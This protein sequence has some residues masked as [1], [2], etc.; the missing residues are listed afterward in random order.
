MMSFTEYPSLAKETIVSE[1]CL[2]IAT[3]VIRSLF[4][5]SS[6]NCLKGTSSRTLRAWSL[7]IK[8]ES[9]ISRR[10]ISHHQ[11]ISQNNLVLP[12]RHPFW[13]FWI[14]LSL[15]CFRKQHEQRPKF[16]TLSALSGTDLQRNFLHRK[17]CYFPKHTMQALPLA[18]DTNAWPGGLWFCGV[19][20]P[21]LTSDPFPSCL[22]ARVKGGVW[23]ITHYAYHLYSHIPKVTVLTQFIFTFR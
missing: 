5:H 4:F 6:V 12:H 16:F 1:K 19:V 21:G 20:L 14:G 18:L 3:F 2:I 9:E 22:T 7:V 13:S 17:K 23:C 10:Y 8:H 11:K 15:S